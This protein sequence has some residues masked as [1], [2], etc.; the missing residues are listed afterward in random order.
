MLGLYI[1]YIPKISDLFR[2]YDVYNLANSNNQRLISLLDTYGSS[3][4]WLP[5]MIII[6]TAKENFVNF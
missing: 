5:E 4:M 2:K 6:E 3:V 1:L